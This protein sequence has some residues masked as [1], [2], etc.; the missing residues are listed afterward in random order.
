MPEYLVNDRAVCQAR[1]LIDDGRFD[2]RTEWSDAAPDAAA[3]NDVIEQEGFDS[4]AAWHL[5]EDPTPRRAQGP[6][7]VPVRRLPHRQ[8]RGADPREATGRPE[9][10]RRDREG[11][12]RAAATAGRAPAELIGST[13]HDLGRR[14]CEEG[15]FVG[16]GA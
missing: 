14:G 13:R 3:A 4:F 1:Q 10:P 16:S 11:G 9:R 15:A 2:D 12:R 6:L 7:R 5:A 8:P